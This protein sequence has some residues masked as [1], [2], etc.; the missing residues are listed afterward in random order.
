MTSEREEWIKK[1]Y[2][3]EDWSLE[4]GAQDS[5]KIL[6]LSPED[7]VLAGWQLEYVDQESGRS[8]SRETHAAFARDESDQLLII[9]TWECESVSAAH[10]LLV[11]I[12]DDFESPFVRRIRGPKVLGDVTFVHEKFTLLYSRANLIILLRN[13]GEELFDVENWAQEFDKNLFS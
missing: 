13:A 7:L 6:R 8:P 5:R 2:E 1:N 9:D 11:N 10:R 4:G 3:F 12:L